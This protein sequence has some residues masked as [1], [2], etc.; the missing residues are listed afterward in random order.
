ML[1]RTVDIGLLLAARDDGHLVAGGYESLRHAPPDISCAPENECLHRV[2]FQMRSRF[3]D[4][5][6]LVAGHKLHIWSLARNGHRCEAA[7]VAAGRT[8]AR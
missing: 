5:L 7:G 2:P 4:C 1:E 6:I 8:A 3:G